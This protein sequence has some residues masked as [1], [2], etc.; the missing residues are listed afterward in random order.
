MHLAGSDSSN[1]CRLCSRKRTLK[2]KVHL[3]CDRHLS[4]ALHFRMSCVQAE[5]KRWVVWMPLLEFQIAL[6]EATWNVLRR[7][8]SRSQA[9]LRDCSCRSDHYQNQTLVLPGPSS[10]STDPSL[11]YTPALSQFGVSSSPP[12]SEKTLFGFLE[13]KLHLSITFHLE[14]DREME[15]ANNMTKGPNSDPLL[16]LLTTISCIPWPNRSNSLSTMVIIACSFPVPLPHF[17]SLM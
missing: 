3:Q 7:W 14:L 10:A 15:W 17:L 12:S 5:L 13:V 1:F 6:T 9:P 4:Q 16:N 8:W 11:A 2:V